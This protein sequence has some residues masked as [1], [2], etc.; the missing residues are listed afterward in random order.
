MFILLIFIFKMV[1]N[2]GIDI[3]D[4]LYEGIFEDG[5]KIWKEEREKLIE[6]KGAI[7]QRIEKEKRDSLS[8]KEKSEKYQKILIDI[9]KTISNILKIDPF[10]EEEELKYDGFEKYGEEDFS[11]YQRIKILLDKIFSECEE[12]IKDD[13]KSG[14][15]LSLMKAA[16]GG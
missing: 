11:N 6:E 13:Y 7:K 2:E 15:V 8:E 1:S 12:L 4:T 14:E 9:K 10:K 5:R 3:N 16:N